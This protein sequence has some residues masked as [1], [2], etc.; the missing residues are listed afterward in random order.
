MR[1]YSPIAFGSVDLAVADH[2]DRF[3]AAEAAGLDETG[4]RG[5][6]TLCWPHYGASTVLCR[7]VEPAGSVE[8]TSPKGE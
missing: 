3:A 4:L 8:D 2:G 6:G 7:R 5:A 1:L